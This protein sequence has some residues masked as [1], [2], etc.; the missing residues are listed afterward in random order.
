MEDGH[1]G[2]VTHN[3]VK[4][5][6]EEYKPKEELVPTQHQRMEVEGALVAV[7][8]QEGVIH[9]DALLQPMIIAVVW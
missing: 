4:V 1:H 2:K 5:V 7:Q 8:R 9:S 6:V 3:A